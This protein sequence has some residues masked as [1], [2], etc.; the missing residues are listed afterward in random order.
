MIDLLNQRCPY[1]GSDTI[2]MD[3]KKI[4]GKDYGYVIACRNYPKCDAYVGCHGKTQIPMGT[5]A[6]K[7]L[8]E[9]RHEAHKYFDPLWKIKIKKGIYNGRYLAY[10]WLSSR[11]KIP[12]NRTHIGMFDE[13]KTKKCIEICKPF[14]ENLKKKGMLKD[15]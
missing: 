14:Y 8:R 15:E 1:C 2:I 3:S 13:K 11:M 7:E 9:L 5:I 10:S 4:Y 12:L 6:N